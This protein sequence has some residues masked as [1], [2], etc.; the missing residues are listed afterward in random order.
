MNYREYLKKELDN[1]VFIEIKKD[2]EY[3]LKNKF[4][5]ESGDYPINIDNF[6]KIVV[7]KEENIKLNYI[8][9]GIIT[10]LGV[11]EN[12]KLKDKYIKFLSSIDGIQSYIINIIETNKASN[13]K[14]SIIFANVLCL[15]FKTE[16]NLINK[17]YLM[18]ELSQK[19]NIDLTYAI[20]ETLKEILEINPDSPSANYNL[21]LLYLN[22]D[23]E[24]AKHFLRK[25]L[26]YPITKKDAQELLDELE[27]VE[28]YDNAIE[29]IKKEDY[30]N[31]LKLLLPIVDKNLDNLNAIYYTAYCY[32]NLGNS[33]KAIYYLNLLPKEPQI[34]EVLVEKGINM[35]QLG[36]F[37][38]AIS[39]F[40]DALKLKPDDQTVICNIGVCQYYNGQLNEALNTLELAL[41]LNKNDEVAAKWL[42]I[43]KEELHNAR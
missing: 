4:I 6:K 33:Q 2:I 10:V 17:F 7:N 41:R 40:R 21:A 25:C 23:R 35:A 27:E 19:M 11:D 24:L 38:E 29:L 36:Y 26:N 5:L 32:R 8:L 34:L 16:V 15:L 13:I 22:S 31:A 28:N 14:K 37:D 43:V 39:I 30:Y 42:Q 12:F 1:I 18:N 3:N 9:D 20:E